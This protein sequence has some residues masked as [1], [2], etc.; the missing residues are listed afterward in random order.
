MKI[1]ITSH[2]NNLESEIDS[3][4]GRAEY[5]IIYDTNT[6]EFEAIHN[7]NTSEGSGV[8]V[9]TG[10]L[11]ADNNVDMV[12]TGHVGPKAASALNAANVK[13]TEHIS[14]VVKDFI[15]TLA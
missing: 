15:S 13:Y 12:Y 11:I 9:K 1:C 7:E 8:G 3:R 14:G 4:F 10:Q 6:K 2:G 5:F